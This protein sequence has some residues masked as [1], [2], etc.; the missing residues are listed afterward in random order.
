MRLIFLI[1]L[2][3]NMLFHQCEKFSWRNG[4]NFLIIILQ[5]L[6]TLLKEAGFP[7]DVLLL[8]VIKRKVS[9]LLQASAE[10]EY[11]VVSQRFHVSAVPTLNSQKNFKQLLRLSDRHF[12]SLSSFYCVCGLK[13]LVRFAGKRIT[14]SPVQTDSEWN[15]LMQRFTASPL[16][17]F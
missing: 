7:F 17:K 15:K 4:G 5:C 9:R 6:A 2:F 1:C 12:S 13:T 10:S 16:L 14:L 3:L 8:D 11:P